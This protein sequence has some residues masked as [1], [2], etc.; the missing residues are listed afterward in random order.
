MTG[1]YACF[2]K[3]SYFPLYCLAQEPMI[4]RSLRKAQ[5]DLSR[6]KGA[7]YL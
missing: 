5:E 3:V 6:R 4:Q 7:L 2:K 1:E